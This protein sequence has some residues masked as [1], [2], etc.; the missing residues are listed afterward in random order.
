LDHDP[1]NLAINFDPE[2]LAEALAEGL[3]PDAEEPGYGS[4]GRIDEDG[5]ESFVIAPVEALRD[6]ISMQGYDP[7]DVVAET[8][9]EGRALLH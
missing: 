2:D 1:I 8:Y 3:R 9:A 5:E 7:S 6:A 4:V